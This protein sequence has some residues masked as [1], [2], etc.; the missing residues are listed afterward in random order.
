LLRQEHIYQDIYQKCLLFEENTIMY[1]GTIKDNVLDHV[2]DISY[3]GVGGEVERPQG[4][5]LHSNTIANQ[6]IT[7]SVCQEAN[8][9]AGL[10]LSRKSMLR[11]N[12]NW[13]QELLSTM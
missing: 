9:D 10:D 1:Q 12:A 6:Y 3:V 13:V 11:Q 2:P 7:K 4:G 5:V 8:V